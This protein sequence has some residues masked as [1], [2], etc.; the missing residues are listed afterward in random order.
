MAVFCTT[1]IEIIEALLQ[2][3][4]FEIGQRIIGE[5]GSKATVRYIG[6]VCSAK[7]KESIWLGVDWDENGRGKHDGS[8]VDENGR[9]IHYFRTQPGKGSFIK[10]GIA[11]SGITMSDS[12]RNRYVSLDSDLSAPNQIIPNAFVNTLKGKLKPIQFI[13]EEKIRYVI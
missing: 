9:I 2:M 1:L 3:A 10:P 11:H 12:L 8:A 5:D 13:G 6:S 7:N 4:I